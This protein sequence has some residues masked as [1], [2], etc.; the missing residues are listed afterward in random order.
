MNN[1]QPNRHVNS[2]VQHKKYEE[3]SLISYLRQLRSDDYSL[4]KLKHAPLDLCT[5]RIVFN[6]YCTVQLIKIGKIQTPFI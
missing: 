6:Q 1:K 5:R 2:A 4:T 3:Q